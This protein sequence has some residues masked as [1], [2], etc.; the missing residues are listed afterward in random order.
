[1]TLS[2]TR[3]FAA[4]KTGNN[5]LNSLRN[6]QGSTI[7]RREYPLGP[8]DL[9]RELSKIA[10]EICRHVSAIDLPAS[11]QKLTSTTLLV[12]NP[13]SKEQMAIYPQ[14]ELGNNIEQRLTSI[15]RTF[16][17]FLAHL[18]TLSQFSGSGNL[19][20]QVVHRFIDIFRVLF[21]RICDLAVAHAKSDQDRPKATKKQD[22]GQKKPHGTS[23]SDERPA[24][25][26]IIMKLCKL[27]ISMLFHLD[28]IK[29]TNKAIL[30]GYFY[31][32]VTRVGEVLK[33]FTVGGRPF[34]IQEHDITSRHD[35]HPREGRQLKTSSAASDAEASEVQAPYLIWMLN[36][37][38]R[39]SSSMSPAINATTTSHDDHRQPEVI[40]SDGSRNAIHDDAR[41]R[42][43]HTLVRAIFGGQVAASFEPT[44]EPSHILPDD[45]IMTNFETETADV[46]DWFKNEVWRLVG[47]E[48]LRGKIAWG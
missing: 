14:A 32:L 5:I 2:A 39:F 38:Q 43:Q 34:G 29:S 1:M 17:H 48:V 13:R 7:A 22:N 23:S 25:S 18:H 27:V 41:I 30:E 42:L 45:D 46:R 40:Q 37:T 9:A 10:T 8:K 4:Y 21:Q 26:P 31:L 33:D 35:P 12:P 3:P 6:I 20:G 44:L 11:F 19:C 16:P 47:W 24:T 15:G 28:P 36:R